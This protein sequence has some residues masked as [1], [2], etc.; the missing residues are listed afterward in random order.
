MAIN[1]PYGLDIDSLSTEAM[2]A[3]LGIIDEVETERKEDALTQLREKTLLVEAKKRRGKTLTAMALSWELRENFGQPV[4]VV[5][6]NM[7]LKSSFG[8]A[9]FMTD[10]EFRQELENIAA[11]ANEADNAEAVVKAF[12]KYGI[13][14]YGATVVFDEARKLFNRR[15]PMDKLCQLFS[16]YLM[17]SAHYHTT[18]ILTAPEEQDIDRRVCKQIDWRGRVYHNKYT[19]IA[20][21]R[22]TQGVETIV[23]EVN[24]ASD[25]EHIPFYEMYDS[26]ALLG[27]RQ[28]A[29]SIKDVPSLAK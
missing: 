18:N 29:L 28:R 7:G 2:E 9:S 5:G 15:A 26:W 12:E 17:Q 4:V 14:I 3:V 11:V 24:G 23:Y 1:N 27:F 16:D 8:P 19:N 21:C 13:K 22:F 6:S 25:T 20:R 10:G